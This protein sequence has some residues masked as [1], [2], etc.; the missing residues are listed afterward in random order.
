MKPSHVVAL[1][2]AGA[3]GFALLL[4]LLT[5]GA[6]F[7][8]LA[9]SGS[10]GIS[11]RDLMVR[12]VYLMLIVVIPVI[13]LAI[14]IAWHYREGNTKA[15]YTP[16]WEHS[17]MEEFIWWSIPFEIVLVLS[18]VTWSGTHE[19]DPMKALVSTQPPLTVQVVALPWKWLF[20]YPEQGVASVN[21]LALPV[22]RPVEFRITADAPMNSF[23]IPALGGQMYAMT[24]MTTMLHLMAPTAGNFTGR[25][26]NYSGAEFA[27]MSFTARAMDQSDF[28]A[29][30]AQAKQAE[31]LSSGTYSSL[32]VPSDAGPVRYYGSV[33][34]TF[35]DILDLYM[36]MRMD[37]TMP[38]G[39]S[40]MHHP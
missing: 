34:M 9:P 20:I 40:M 29:W 7:P 27:Q 24:G 6:G 31:A 1:G 22:N 26:A 33:D 21:E 13:I 17:K 30:V 39:S 5:H 38:M 28:D 8:L 15:A 37:M 19:L 25:S 32:R 3:V 36:P 18:A 2:G 23:W 12:T 4:M 14:F 35:A 11:E 10:V 16:N